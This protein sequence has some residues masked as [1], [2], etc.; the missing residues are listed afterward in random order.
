MLLTQ[1][2]FLLRARPCVE[3]SP[4]ALMFQLKKEFK[5]EVKQRVFLTHS[6]S[7]EKRC[8]IRMVHQCHTDLFQ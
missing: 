2:A 4:N 1:F 5:S 8:S 3:T 7:L 6:Q